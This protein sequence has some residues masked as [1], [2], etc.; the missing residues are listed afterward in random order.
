MKMP[1]W[2]GTALGATL[3]ARE[4]LAQSATV[5]DR[6]SFHLQRLTGIMVVVERATLVSVGLP[7][8]APRAATLPSPKVKIGAG[9]SFAITGGLQPYWQSNRSRLV[10]VGRANRFTKS[11]QHND[12]KSAHTYT[13][14]GTGYTIKRET[15]TQNNNKTRETDAKLFSSMK[16]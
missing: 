5:Q 12:S 1:Q 6:V 15:L 7:L 9:K 4:A 10:L 14:R 8:R 11:Q 3:V 16:R 13:E 2:R